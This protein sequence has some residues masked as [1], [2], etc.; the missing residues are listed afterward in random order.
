MIRFKL[1]ILNS[2]V[3]GLDSFKHRSRYCESIFSLPNL[4]LTLANIAG[5]KHKHGD[6][7]KKTE[8]HFFSQNN[9]FL[10]CEQA[11]GRAGNKGEGKA[12]PFP[13]YFFPQTESLFTG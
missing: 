4:K 6:I 12:L 3:I 2:Y 1:S 11:F 5:R 10:A 7:K 13:C 9:L 8:E